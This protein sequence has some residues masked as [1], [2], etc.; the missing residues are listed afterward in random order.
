M[1]TMRTRES[2][3]RPASHRAS[4]RRGCPSA[5]TGGGPPRTAASPSRDAR[6]VHLTDT[7]YTPGR[8]LKKTHLLRWRPRPHAE[9]TQSTPHV[10]PS[11]A[12]S[13]LDLFE[14]PAEFFRI[15]LEVY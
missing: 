6:E 7:G 13:H 12:A 3:S 5:P 2:A 4:T 10:R 14:R 11:G 1:S 8:P 15:L 9:R